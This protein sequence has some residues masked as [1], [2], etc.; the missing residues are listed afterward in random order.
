M[1]C[2]V[3]DLQVCWVELHWLQGHGLRTAQ[4]WSLKS[5]S[6]LTCSESGLRVAAEAPAE[7]AEKNLGSPTFHESYWLVNRDPDNGLMP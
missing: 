3:D 6:F 2:H 7:Q 4:R 1:S 5:T